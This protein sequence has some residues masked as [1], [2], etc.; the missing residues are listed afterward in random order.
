M[1]KLVLD[2]ITRIEGHLRIDTRI[3]SGRVVEAWSKGEMFRG[4]EALLAGRDP[5]DAPA[6]TQRICGVCPVSHGIAA[7]RALEKAMGIDPPPNGRLLRNLILGANFLQNHILHFYQL[8]LLD[9]IRVEAILDRPAK[10]QA[11]RELQEWV[12]RELASPRILP[13]APFLPQIADKSI[14]TDWSVLALEHYLEALEMRREAHKMGAL[15]GGKMPH[16]ASLVPGGV[17]CGVDPEAVESFRTRLRQL[18]R[19]VENRYLPDAI[20]V[21]HHFPTY[22]NIGRGV[23]RYLSVGAFEEERGSWLAGGLLEEGKLSPLDTRLIREE[24]TSSYYSSASGGSPTEGDLEVEQ[25]KTGAYSWI[26]APRYDGVP[27]EVGPLARLMIAVAAGDRKV[28]TLLTNCR[29]E[30]RLN[31]ENWNSMLGRHLARAAEASLVA[32]QMECWLDQLVWGAQSVAPLTPRFKG[33][34]E[35]LMEAPRGALGHWLKIKEGRLSHYQ[36]IVPST[37]NFSP[38]DARGGA[39]PVEAALFGTPVASSLQG[40]EVARVVR[41]FDPCIAC[42]VH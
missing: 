20:R 25:H 12:K 8:S 32:E 18:R 21:A 41:S 34:G 31:R 19:F 42:A 10:S 4:F 6:L 39:G 33:E 5:F 2:P 30:A 26:K 40:L 7:S 29:K 35:G 28:T 16:P 1:A 24:V 14:D 11:L 36:C 17:T 9:F 23:G 22:A 37:W 27:C 15:L 13:A 38:R 3:E